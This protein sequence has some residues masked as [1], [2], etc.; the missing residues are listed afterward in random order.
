MIDVVHTLHLPRK[1]RSNIRIGYAGDSNLC[2]FCGASGFVPGKLCRCGVYCLSTTSYK[3]PGS[4][5]RKLPP[6]KLGIYKPQFDGISI[7]TN[8][9]F[10]QPLYM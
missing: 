8:A 3:K 2:P 9:K 7:E 10:N 6:S 1:Y 4:K 5:R